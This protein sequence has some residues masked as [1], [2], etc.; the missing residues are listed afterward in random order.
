MALAAA[1]LFADVVHLKGGGR[2]TGEIV[3][4]TAESVTV[5]IGGGNLSVGA[6]SVVRIEK[7]SSP[8][9][10]FRARAASIPPGD[11]EAWRELGDWAASGGQ[12][13]LAS[14]AYTQVVAI[15]PDDP[16]ANRALGRIQYNGAWVTEE[17]AYRAQGYVEF[18]GE[19]MRPAE[20]Q[21]ILAERKAE[22]EAYQRTEEAR[23][24]A[25]EADRR[26][27]EAQEE[28]ERRA[29]MTGG[30]PQ[31]GDPIPWGY[32]PGSWPVQPFS[33]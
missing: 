11:A 5:N 6:G 7:S 23:M 1:P 15:V 16:E 10:E 14:Q 28:A 20:R 19:W 33:Q 30:L 26:E 24:Q 18:E 17:E 21:S 3:E 13:T 4:Q 27:R 22:E 31:Y 25:E 2:I 29:F 8:V 32:G 12:A 9:Q